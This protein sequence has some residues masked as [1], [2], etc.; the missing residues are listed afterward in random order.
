MKWVTDELK[1]SVSNNEKVLVFAHH[2]LY[3]FSG[4]TALNDKEILLTLKNYPCV[5]AV[6]NGH[7]HTGAF[8][9]YYHIPCITTEGMIETKD[10]TAYAVVDIFTDKIVIS[11]TGRTRSYTLLFN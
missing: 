9:Y 7:H 3:P 6:I 10:T 11:G 2:P 1:Q 8:G 5:K 4:Y